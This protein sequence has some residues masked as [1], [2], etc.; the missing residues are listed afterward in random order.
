LFSLKSK[1]PQKVKTKNV[2]VNLRG[3]IDIYLLTGFAEKLF[4]CSVVQLQSDGRLLP[5]LKL[6]GLSIH[7]FIF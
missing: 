7:N 4:F 1:K 3:F 6:W 2:H 5:I